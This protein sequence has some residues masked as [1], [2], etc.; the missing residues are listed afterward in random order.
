M[1]DLWP[2]IEPDNDSSDYG[3]ID[4]VMKDQENPD[5][6]KQEEV[7]SFPCRNSMSLTR[8]D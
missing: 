3:S 7:V 1:S 4:G 2:D 5:D 6:Q 8:G